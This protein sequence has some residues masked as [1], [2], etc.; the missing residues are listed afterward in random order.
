[1]LDLLTPRQKVVLDFIVGFIGARQYPPSI[2]EIGTA[3]NIRSTNGVND[4]ILRLQKKGWLLPRNST[5]TARGLVLSAEACKH[6]GVS[7]ETTNSR[8]TYRLNA[9]IQQF[10][11]GFEK[12]LAKCE[13]PLDGA[14]LVLGAVD[15]I[16]REEV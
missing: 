16:F 15:E 14:T 8:L 2:R 9:L 11:A 3:T 10:P 5:M 6:Y 4:H 13:T 1:M 7:M 12:L